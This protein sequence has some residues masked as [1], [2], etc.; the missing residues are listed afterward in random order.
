MTI[1]TLH[2]GRILADIFSRD[3]GAISHGA[4]DYFTHKIEQTQ[5]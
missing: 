1:V 2:I 3:A 5:S 4:N